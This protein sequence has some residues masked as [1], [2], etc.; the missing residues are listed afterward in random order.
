MCGEKNLNEINLHKIVSLSFYNIAWEF[1]LVFASWREVISAAM[2][3]GQ[4][5]SLQFL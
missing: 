3:S 2:Y 5:S 4:S 1:P